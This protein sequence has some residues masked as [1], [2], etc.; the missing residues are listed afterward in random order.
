MIN[1]LVKMVRDR[2]SELFQGITNRKTQYN[3]R[4]AEIERSIRREIERRMLER[5][6]FSAES[7]RAPRNYRPLN[8]GSS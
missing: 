1:N 4:H 5:T 8:T 2:P 6:R 3:T 7:R